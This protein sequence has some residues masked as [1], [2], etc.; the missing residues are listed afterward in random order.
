MAASQRAPQASLGQAQNMNKS[1]VPVV[2]THYT[3][4]EGGEWIPLA[5][6]MA[7]GYPRHIETVGPK[8][9]VGHS[10]ARFEGGKL[11]HRWDTITGWTVEPAP[12]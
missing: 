10:F 1:D 3:E 6:G 7:L 12:A 2:F 8:S 9:P 11:T 5:Q 4:Y